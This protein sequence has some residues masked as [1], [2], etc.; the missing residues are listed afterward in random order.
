M[1][2]GNKLNAPTVQAGQ[3]NQ[4]LAQD[5][6]QAKPVPSIEEPREEAGEDVVYLPGPGDP[7][8]IKWRGL[9]FRANVPRRIADA[10]H[11][12][13][14]RTNRFFR[15]GKGD[16]KDQGRN[17]NEGPKNPMEYRAHVVAWIKTCNSVEDVIRHWSDD[18]VLRQTCEVGDD[19]IKWLGTMAEPVLADLRKKQGM[20]DADVMRVWIKYGVLDL[21]WRG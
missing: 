9:E 19:D 5:N 2:D 15:V 1:A 12:E 6:T 20:S 13:A 10:H 4:A 14:A 8:T 17:P 21:P 3:H 11:I 16:P 18:R 7:A